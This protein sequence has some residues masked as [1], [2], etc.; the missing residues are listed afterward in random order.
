MIPNAHYER[1]FRHKTEEGA[2]PRAGRRM[3]LAAAALLLV[4]AAAFHAAGTGQVTVLN[5]ESHPLVG[6]I[7]AVEIEVLE[8]EI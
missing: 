2:P 1:L 6:G 7:W 5:P 4:A 8:G 3:P